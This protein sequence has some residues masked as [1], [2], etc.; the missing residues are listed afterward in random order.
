MAA[1]SR[2]KNDR[3]G[4]THW[5]IPPMPRCGRQESTMI[6]IP[7][8]IAIARR[9]GL[10]GAGIALGLLAFVLLAPSVASAQTADSDS[11][12]Y[13]GG[14]LSFAPNEGQTDERVR[15]LSQGAGY[16]FFFTDDKA[17]LSFTKAG[18]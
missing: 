12:P 3:R 10:L 5:V 17:V 13:E 7:D 9:L 1:K 11:A 16:S 14:P 4:G 8:P 18:D 6:S 2:R 15:Y